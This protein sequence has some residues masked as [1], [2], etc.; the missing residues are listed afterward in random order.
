MEE[1]AEKYI[2]GE[3]YVKELKKIDEAS[4]L[5]MTGGKGM[6]WIMKKIILDQQKRL[7]E[8]EFY[9]AELKGEVEPDEDQKLSL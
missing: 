5:D 9:V 3:V 6:I 4:A 2:P 1:E 8:L 7:N